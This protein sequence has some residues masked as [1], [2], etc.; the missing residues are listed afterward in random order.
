MTQHWWVLKTHYNAQLLWLPRLC[1]S[2]QFDRTEIHHYLM[3]WYQ[4]PKTQ[5]LILTLSVPNYNWDHPPWKTS[6]HYQ[7]QIVNVPKRE[8]KS[9][10]Y[11]TQITVLDMNRQVS[12]LL[13]TKT[14][15]NKPFHN[16]SYHRHAASAWPYRLFFNLRTTLSCSPSILKS[17]GSSMRTGSPLGISAWAK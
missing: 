6:L 15:S 16:F 7:S 14:R 13:I 17:L 11:T 1:G 9:S 2:I 8:K 12:T 10:T 3:S 4:C 5:T